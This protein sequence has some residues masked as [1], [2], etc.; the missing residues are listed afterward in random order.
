MWRPDASNHDVNGVNE[1]VGKEG[2]N[3][4][5]EVVDEQRFFG[6]EVTIL[7][8]GQPPDLSGNIESFDRVFEGGGTKILAILQDKM[9][10]IVIQAILTQAKEEIVV[11]GGWK[12]GIVPGEILG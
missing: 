10:E 9:I 8:A 5:L 12:R 4:D 1:K 3:G 11:L 7:G 2:D 6:G